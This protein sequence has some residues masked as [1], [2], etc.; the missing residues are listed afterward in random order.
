MEYTKNTNP[1]FYAENESNSNCGS[2]AFNVEEWYNPEI[3]LEAE[4]LYIGTWMAEL[5]DSGYSCDEVADIYVETLAESVLKDFEGEIREIL[6]PSQIHNDEEL[7][8]FRGYCR[9]EIGE[10]YLPDYDFHFKVLRNGIW[11]EKCGSL[12]VK[13]CT[14]D[15]WTYTTR[16]YNSETLYFAHRI[17]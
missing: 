14:E 15:D 5:I 9:Y 13:F 7:I 1:N 10:D 11:Q 4:V 3:D 6:F 2:F 12:P 16:T 8:A 17:D